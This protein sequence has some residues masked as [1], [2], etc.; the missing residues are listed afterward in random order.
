MKKEGIVVFA[1]GLLFTIFTGFNFV[2]KEKVVDV[3]KL[4]IT[5][6][7]DNGFAWSPL[8][9]VAVMVLGGGVFL[10]GEKRT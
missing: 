9:G 3:G 10:F 7:K 5:K 2:K 4:E 6:D 8:L 1:I